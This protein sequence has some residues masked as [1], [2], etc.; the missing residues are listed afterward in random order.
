MNVKWISTV[1]MAR[2]GADGL[3]RQKHDKVF[4]S[5]SLNDRGQRYF[6][7]IYGQFELDLYANPANYLPQTRFCSEYCIENEYYV[8]KTA[9]QALQEPLTGKLFMFPPVALTAQGLHLLSLNPSVDYSIVLLIRSQFLGL[10]RGLFSS[11]PHFTTK[12][13]ETC[14]QTKKKYLNQKISGN[15]LVLVSYGNAWSYL[16]GKEEVEVQGGSSG[17]AKRRCLMDRGDGSSSG[18]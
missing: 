17:D 14:T 12:L 11:K 9:Q 16:K 4:D 7:R 1:E 18:K 2:D 13:F 15:D 10:C 3:S 8:G 6:T 5:Y